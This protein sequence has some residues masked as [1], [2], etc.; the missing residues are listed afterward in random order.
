MSFFSAIKNKLTGFA[1]R[2]KD[3]K[4]RIEYLKFSAVG[5]FTSFLDIFV[6]GLVIYIANPTIYKSFMGAFFDSSV[7]PEAFTVVTG[8]GIGFL[9][10]F[11][12]NYVLSVF[13][14]YNYGNIGKSTKG[15]LKFMLLAL[16]GL[17]VHTVGEFLGF[18]IFKLNFWLVKIF[19]TIVMFIFNYFSRKYFIFNIELIRDENQ[20][21]NL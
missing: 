4:G 19:L 8:T 11:M 14:V 9:L 17:V 21:I 10:S 15:F 16:I 7:T 18:H 3:K 2:L 5:I 1:S 12:A 20:T 6:M 13:F